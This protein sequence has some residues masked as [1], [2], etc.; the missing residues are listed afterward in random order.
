[1]TQP[2]FPAMEHLKVFKGNLELAIFSFENN[3]AKLNT[4]KCLLLISGT[5]YGRS[6]AKIYDD[7]I[8]ESNEV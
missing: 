4:D 2:L 7:K 3:Y 8:W 1:M 5:K 6:W